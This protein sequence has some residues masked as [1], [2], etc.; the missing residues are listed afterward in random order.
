M[1]SEASAPALGWLSFPLPAGVLSGASGVEMALRLGPSAHS[2]LLSA[3]QGPPR[4]PLQLQWKW[5]EGSLL[6]G[7]GLPLEHVFRFPRVW[8]PRSLQAHEALMTR[9]RVKRGSRS[10][11]CFRELAVWH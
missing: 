3:P 6:G 1:L 8:P 2:D 9:D 4:R 7:T 11:S 10:G 5:M